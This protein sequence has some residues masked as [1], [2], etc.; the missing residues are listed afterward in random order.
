MMPRI[1]LKVFGLF[2]ILSSLLVNSAHASDFK[3]PHIVLKRVVAVLVAQADDL[4]RGL[5]GL[6]HLSPENEA[7]KEDYIVFL[8]ETLAY[9]QSL[10][11]NPDGTN[12]KELAVDLKN[13]RKNV[14]NEKLR[15]ISDFLLVFQAKSVLGIAENRF[16]KIYSDLDRLIELKILAKDKSETLLNESHLLLVG[17][18]DLIDS[19][20]GLLSTSTEARLEIRSLIAEAVI[21]IKSAYKKFLEISS[22]LKEALR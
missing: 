8:D 10:E 5:Y 3:E 11:I 15:E 21:R 1:I 18:S 12:V 16:V 13:R 17:A 14:H 22:L 9:Y 19:A 4:K 2:F 7:L 6:K 20:E